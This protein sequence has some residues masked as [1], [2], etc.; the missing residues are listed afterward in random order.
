MAH[1]YR[2]HVGTPGTIGDV[3]SY[4]KEKRLVLTLSHI[5]TNSV[6]V[7]VPNKANFERYLKMTSRESTDPGGDIVNCEYLGE[8]GK[9]SSKS[10]EGRLANTRVTQFLK[11][12]KKKR[13]LL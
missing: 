11:E 1:I 12:K 8:T 5:E 2:I 10:K 3:V 9:A 13:K 7:V 6:Q 4:L